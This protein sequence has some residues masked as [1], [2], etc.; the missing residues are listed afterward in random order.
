MY[1]GS[2]PYL[3]FHLHSATFICYIEIDKK[4]HLICATSQIKIFNIHFPLSFHIFLWNFCFL[5]WNRKKVIQFVQLLRSK[6]LTYTF[7]FLSTSFTFYFEKSYSSTCATTQNKFSNMPRSTTTFQH[8][9][10]SFSVLY[11]LQ[12][13]KFFN[14]HNSSDLISKHTKNRYLFSHF[15]SASFIFC[16]S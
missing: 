4:S 13:K 6:F 7:L 8:F 16:T 2:L 3:T 1:K 10:L 12:Q 15:R 5:H 9:P 11:F 14:L